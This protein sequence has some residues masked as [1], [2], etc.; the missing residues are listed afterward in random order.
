MFNSLNQIQQNHC[1]FDDRLEMLEEFLLFCIKLLAGK[2]NF[3]FSLIELDEKGIFSVYDLEQINWGGMEV[4]D[5]K[6]VL[7]LIALGP[8]SIM[9]IIDEESILA[10]V[11]NG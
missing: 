7:D 10:K 9:S 8:M 11:S 3:F 1:S 2:K 6:E 4:G 5:N